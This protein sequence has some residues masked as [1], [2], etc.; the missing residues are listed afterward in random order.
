MTRYFYSLVKTKQDS[1]RDSESIRDRI[2]KHDN[3]PPHVF[4]TWKSG[5]A[6]GREGAVS[7]TLHGMYSLH[8]RRDGG[9]E[10]R[11]DAGFAKSSVARG[12][13][14]REGGRREDRPMLH[15]AAD[16]SNKLEFVKSESA[17]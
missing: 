4:T 3:L 2:E 16:Y 17:S 14:V 7:C 6:G 1:S 10:K 12:K 9:E 15:V 8:S 11:R 5:A 13:P